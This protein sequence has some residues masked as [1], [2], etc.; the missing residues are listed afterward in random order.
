ML[1]CAALNACAPSRGQEAPAGAEAGGGVFSGAIRFYQGPLGHL[2]AVRRGPC[3]MFPSCSEYARQAV[4]AHGP[5]V[6]SATGG[7]PSP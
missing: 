3:P 1:A 4:A 5:L 2:D 7:R 6:A